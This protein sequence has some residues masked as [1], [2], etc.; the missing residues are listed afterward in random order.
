MAGN[1][2]RKAII[3]WRFRQEKSPSVVAV[4]CAEDAALVTVAIVIPIGRGG[5]ECRSDE[6]TGKIY[7]SPRHFVT[8]RTYEPRLLFLPALVF[9]QGLLHLNGRILNEWGHLDIST[10]RDVLQ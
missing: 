6:V 2:N 5:L 9:R 1:M 4:C 7:L 3:S 8:L 10:L